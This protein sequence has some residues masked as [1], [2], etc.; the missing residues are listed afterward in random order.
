M[1]I[2]RILNT[3]LRPTSRMLANQLLVKRS[4][5]DVFLAQKSLLGADPVRTVF[6]LGAHVGKT[7]Q[8]YRKTF[9]DAT[10]Y[11]FEPTEATF[12]RLSERTGS[13]KNIVRH[14][15]AV[16]DRHGPLEFH[17]NSQASTNSVFKS[18]R[19]AG[20]Y[21]D[22]TKM[23]TQHVA[24]VQATTLDMFCKEERI[25][26][27]DV[28]K[29]DIQGGELLALQGAVDLLSAKKIRLIF[30][31]VIFVPTYEGQPQVHEIMAWLKGHG[32]VLHNFYR[33]ASKNGRLLYGDA[34]FVAA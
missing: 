9:P 12:S 8:K 13:D 26:C 3:L 16:S 5:A 2:K 11:C 34:I 18:D 25:N 15:M 23:Q 28:L 14:M 17:H 33:L 22:E 32:Y 31:E 4:E 27:I 7:A 24:T 1:S 10:V 6:D 20:L 19:E 21:W 29:M 30:M